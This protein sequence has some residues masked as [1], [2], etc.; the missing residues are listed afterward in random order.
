MSETKL[1]KSEIIHF[2]ERVS[3]LYITISY[4]AGSVL[5]HSLFDGHP[6]VI[7]FPRL[8][9]WYNRIYDNLDQAIRG[10]QTAMVE[11]IMNSGLLLPYAP[12]DPDV[13]IDQERYRRTLQSLLDL[14][15][16]T[17]RRELVALYH[18]ALAIILG[19]DIKAIRYIILHD[20]TPGGTLFEQIRADF[21]DP[22]IIIP[23]RDPRQA[24]VGPVGQSSKVFL[25]K[26]LFKGQSLVANLKK[27]ARQPMQS[28]A[29]AESSPAR[30]LL[31]PFKKA[32][33]LLWLALSPRARA[34]AFCAQLN[35]DALG[36]FLRHEHDDMRATDLNQLHAHG[37]ESMQKLCQWLSIDFADGL[38]HSTF[39]GNTWWG[40]SSNQQKLS[41]FD[42]RRAAFTFQDKLAPDLL[43]ELEFFSE[44]ALRFF[45]QPSP[46][47][48]PPTETE[49]ARLRRIY[50]RLFK[51]A[52]WYPYKASIE[53]ILALDR[54]FA[55]RQLDPRVMV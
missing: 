36:F 31:L 16:P 44:N 27:V 7:A 30:K 22:K 25:R 13:P 29:A 48:Q 52:Q 38:L 42:P 41:G 9:G 8:W 28:K 14:H 54:R 37:P 6:Q 40:N 26:T 35:Y 51:I 23:L 15:P 20:H 18:L 21:P 4:N 19:Y 39:L 12:T 5:L 3:A 47:T 33:S 45:G 1:N 55:N 10:G 24:C 49:E 17:S 34:V 32:T 53:D 2:I 11:T 43:Q 50:A 46:V